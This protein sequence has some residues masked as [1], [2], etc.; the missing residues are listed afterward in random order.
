MRK[1]ADVE[2]GHAWEVVVARRKF[3][4]NAPRNRCA[5]ANRRA[6]ARLRRLTIGAQVIN[7][8]HRRLWLAGEDVQ[9]VELGFLSFTISLAAEAEVES[10]EFDVGLR[11]VGV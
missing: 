3:S 11:P 10:G 6:R 9:A 7:L 2:S 8:P 1:A 5:Q 4:E